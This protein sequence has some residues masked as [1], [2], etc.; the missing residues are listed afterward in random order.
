MSEWSDG[1]Q[2]S[3]R[4]SKESNLPLDQHQLITSTVSPQPNGSN[5][6]QPQ[7]RYTPLKNINA[8]IHLWVCP[9]STLWSAT[10]CRPRRH[11]STDHQSLP[12]QPSVYIAAYLQVFQCLA[13]MQCLLS[14]RKSSD[15]SSYSPY[16]QTSAT[17]AHRNVSHLHHIPTLPSRTAMSPYRCHWE[18]S[19]S[20]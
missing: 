12:F 5:N 9:Q 6:N 1:Q 20:N 17:A 19:S 15:S 18:E 3:C 11:Q 13:V 4:T 14:L 8:S 16:L 10:C 7:S 2:S